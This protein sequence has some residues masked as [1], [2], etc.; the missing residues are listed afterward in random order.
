MSIRIEIT[1]D[2]R[3]VG[4]GRGARVR[5]VL[6]SLAVVGAVAAAAGVGTYSAFTATTQN[7][8]NTFASGSVAIEDNDGGSTAMLGLANAKPNDNDTSCIRVRYTGTI[9]SQVKL[10]AATTGTLPQYLTLT[11][12]RGAGA[13]GFDNC[14]G[15]T[16]D[17]G[18]Y[19]YGA[20]GILYNGSLSAFPTTFAAGITDPD[21]SWT[22][23]EEQW[24][25]FQISL[26]DNDAAKS[27][28][29]SATFT[30]E[31]RSL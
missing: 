26:A 25:R 28:T 7:A 11:V 22:S 8:G 18:S 12:T 27:Q 13:A 4:G 3:P 5:K 20:N 29:G 23:G 24:Y 17:N 14:T 10:Y 19:G 9:A 15:F 31:A 30:W 1:R 16:S 6:L 21:A 2:G